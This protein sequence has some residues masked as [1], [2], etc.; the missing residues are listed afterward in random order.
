VGSLKGSQEAPI[1]DEEPISLIISFQN[2]P[3]PRVEGRCDHKV[4]LVRG[5]PDLPLT[6]QALQ[7]PLSEY[8]LTDAH[9]AASAPLYTRIRRSRAR[10]CAGPAGT[11]PRSRSTRS[12]AA[13]P[14]RG[15]GVRTRRLIDSVC[16]LVQ[17]FKRYR[18]SVAEWEELAQALLRHAV[19]FEVMRV[20]KS[21]HGTKYVIQGG[22]LRRMGGIPWFARYGLSKRER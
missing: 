5:F 21:R 16:N 10:C 8:G 7:Q 18:F 22:W 1:A 19:E 11:A 20:N 17:F 3:D 6:A 14:T 2:L 13:A 15:R 12:C 4:A 9:R